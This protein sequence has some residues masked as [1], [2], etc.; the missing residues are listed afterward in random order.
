MIYIGAAHTPTN[1]VMAAPNHVPTG[2][3]VL[4]PALEFIVDSAREFPTWTFKVVRL[5][6]RAL[7]A[8]QQ[9]YA[10]QIH[11][12]NE[13][14]KARGRIELANYN[15]YCQD[16]E[17]RNDRIR[18]SLQRGD[19]K[20]T[21]KGTVAIKIVRKWFTEPSLSEQ[22]EVA[23]SKIQDLRT[24]KLHTFRN[25]KT[26]VESTV[27]TLVRDHIMANIESL[28][29]EVPA[30]KNNAYN[31]TLH[32]FKDIQDDYAIAHSVCNGRG[33]TVVIQDDKYVI[34][35]GRSPVEITTSDQLPE[36]VRRAIGM[37]KLVENGQFIRDMGFRAEEN[38]Y[39]V[40]EPEEE[41]CKTSS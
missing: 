32:K 36:G 33:L 27:L 8:G 30:L 1:I 19:C 31:L 7:D 9:H 21:S 15:F 25:Q 6:I 18:R 5:N 34:Q 29:E 23:A 12:F 37:L 16:V 10:I 38:L 14:G 13:H 40:V 26:H 39:F 24:N 17:F 4:P 11:V 3:E 41:Q 28:W 2:Q 22:M 20:R 35:R